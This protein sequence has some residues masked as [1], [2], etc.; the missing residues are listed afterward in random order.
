MADKLVIGCGYLGRVVA[1]RWK[2]AG[3]RVIATTRTPKRAAELRALGYEPVVCDVLRP[4]SLLALPRSV[5]TILQCVG[6]DRGS[7]V[8]IRAV[9]VEGLAHVLSALSGWRGRFIHVSSPSVYGQTG[10]E[11]VDEDAA[12]QPAE[13][14]GR[15]ALEAELLLAERRPDAIIL[16]F[17]GIYGPGRLLRAR[18]IVAG[19]ALAADPETWLN[20]IH[21]EDGAAAVVAADERGRPGAVYNIADDRP[22]PRRQFYTH[23]AAVLRAPHARFLPPPGTRDANRRIANRRMKQEL[24]V[25]L[26]YANSIEGLDSSTC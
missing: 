3:D 15:V 11:E 7:G 20:L 22:V 14:A 5:A 17:A 9:C 6:F 4:A 24:G 25:S 26:L 23:L 1:A 16:R 19:E 13:E 8:S 21:V 2:S 18:E 10:G 12:T